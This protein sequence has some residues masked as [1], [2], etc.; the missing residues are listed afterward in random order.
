MICMGGLT[1]LGLTK[2]IPGVGSVPP[3]ICSGGLGIVGL[4]LDHAR[5]VQCPMLCMGG[6][7]I[8]SVAMIIPGLSSVQ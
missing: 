6:L 1:T 4:T 7:E 2:I 5:C 3:I 8:E